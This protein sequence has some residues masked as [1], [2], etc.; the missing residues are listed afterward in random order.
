MGDLSLSALYISHAKCG[1][2]DQYV[3]SL[4]LWIDDQ[5]SYQSFALKNK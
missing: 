1:E 4:G 2:V 3:K 5:F